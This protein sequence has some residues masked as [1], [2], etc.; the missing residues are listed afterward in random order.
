[1]FTSKI[2]R[3]VLIRP[4]LWRTTI[5][6]FFA[7]V[8]DRWW[9]RWPFVPIPDREVVAWRVTTAY[10][11]AE[12]TLVCDDVLAYLEWRQEHCP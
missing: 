4:W 6:A 3:E 8:P 5:G 10:G 7:L 11:Q 2:A 12:M 9:T 1:M